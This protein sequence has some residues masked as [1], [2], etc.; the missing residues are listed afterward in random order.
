MYALIVLVLLFG[1]SGLWLEGRGVNSDQLRRAWRPQK[2]KKKKGYESDSEAY[3]YHSSGDEEGSWTH[4]PGGWTQTQP[5]VRRPRRDSEER[6]TWKEKIQEQVKSRYEQVKEGVADVKG[7]GKQREDSDVENRAEAQT[8]REVK[9]TEA[10]E[11][12][13]VQ[14]CSCDCCSRSRKDS[15]EKVS[16]SRKQH[17]E[18]LAKIKESSEKALEA[19]KRERRTRE[20]QIKKDIE[21]L[22]REMAKESLRRESMQKSLEQ[23]VSCKTSKGDE[24]VTHAPKDE[25]GQKQSIPS[26]A[27]DDSVERITKTT[28]RKSTTVTT[29]TVDEAQDKQVPT[30]S[31]D[32]DMVQDKSEISPSSSKKGKGKALEVDKVTDPVADIVEPPLPMPE[33]PGKRVEALPEDPYLG[34]K[35]ASVV[36]GEA[37][38]ESPAVKGKKGK[39]KAAPVAEPGREEEKGDKKH[40]EGQASVEIIEETTKKK[41]KESSVA[42]PIQADEDLG[43]EK[44]EGKISK[45]FHILTSM[46]K[47]ITEEVLKHVLEKLEDKPVKTNEAGSEP[48]KAAKGAPDIVEA[49]KEVSEGANASEEAKS[50]QK[51]DT[52]EQASSAVEPAAEA[53]ATGSKKGNKKNKKKETEET[54]QEPA[55]EVEQEGG[56]LDNGK[57]GGTAVI[58]EDVQE[59]ARP[60]L[61]AAKVEV[62]KTTE[63]SQSQSQSE[64]VVITKTSSSKEP[65][66]TSENDN[67]KKPPIPDSSDKIS[68]PAEPSKAALKCEKGKEK[69]ASIGQVRESE[70]TDT[71][72]KSKETGLQVPVEDLA[73]LKAL[74]ML[75]GRNDVYSST[76]NYL[77][78]LYPAV[79]NKSSEEVNKAIDDQYVRKSAEQDVKVGSDSSF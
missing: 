3:E 34:A 68:P 32:V 13:S 2:G 28:T 1:L 12:K 45:G 60:A 44:E 25:C 37:K 67:S 22:K 75:Q 20:E 48:A 17:E 39:Q 58:E 52:N 38:D 29:G 40:A 19:E 71:L 50:G 72:E 6:K 53:M 4:L 42:E 74:A 54:T 16:G 77:A 43:Q 33:A 27:E 18:E 49:G 69:E 56:N 57:K 24:E 35:A 62:K 63:E 21:E 65:V 10:Q 11:K 9:G 46:T 5:M 41:E 23:S 66:S 7:K 26:K 51:V 8:A 30:Q 79:V 14:E 76:A 78:E 61:E 64:K 70:A 59:E 15:N 31:T 73:L 47:E 55:Q 36:D